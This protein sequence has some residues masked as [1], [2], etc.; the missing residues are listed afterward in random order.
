MM[1]YVALMLS[2]QILGI[3]VVERYNF[4]RRYYSQI[5]SN[6]PLAIALY[7][8]LVLEERL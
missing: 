8:V 5:I 6:A 1:R 7:S 3:A 2:H 4:E